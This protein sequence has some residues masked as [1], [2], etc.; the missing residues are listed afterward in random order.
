MT[1]G[2]CS[3]PP[4]TNTWEGSER[5]PWRSLNFPMLHNLA[6][7]AGGVGGYTSWNQEFPMSH[8]KAPHSGTD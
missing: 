3:P 2:P 6:P 7:P 8:A 1:H 5:W 4:L